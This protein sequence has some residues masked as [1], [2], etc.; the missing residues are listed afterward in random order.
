MVN[1]SAEPQKR[2]ESKL[3]RRVKQELAEEA[4]AKAAAD[5]KIASKKGLAPGPDG[6][7]AKL[8][9]EQLAA[10]PAP[11]GSKKPRKF[12]SKGTHCFLSRFESL[13]YCRWLISSC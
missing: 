5:V 13:A 11:S 7:A 3:L 9:G 10:R 6:L 4:A 2:K 8:P 1:G 12:S